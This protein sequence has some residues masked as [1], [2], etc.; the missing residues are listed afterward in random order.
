MRRRIVRTRERTLSLEPRVVQPAKWDVERE[1]WDAEMGESVRYVGRKLGATLAMW[2]VEH[3]MP[4]SAAHYPTTT[5]AA[6][7][8]CLLRLVERTALHAG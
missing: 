3:F 6:P 7:G 8:K 4:L 2:K 1:S 5:R